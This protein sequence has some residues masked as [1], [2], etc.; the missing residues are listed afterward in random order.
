MPDSDWPTDLGQ[1]RV[2]LSDFDYDSDFGDRRQEIVFIGAGMDEKAICEKLDAALLTDEEMGAY[3][4]R[5]AAVALLTAPF[6]G[7]NRHSL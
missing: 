5:Y 2:I 7:T 4:Q 1:R 3:K 6:L